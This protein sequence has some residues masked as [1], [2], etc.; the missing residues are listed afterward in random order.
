[1]RTALL[2]VTLLAACH[3]AGPETPPDAPGYVSICDQQPPATLPHCE[4]TCG[5]GRVDACS[6]HVIIADQCSYYQDTTEDCDGAAAGLGCVDLGYYGGTPSCNTACRAVATGCGACAT[7]PAIVDCHADDALAAMTAA[8]GSDPASSPATLAVATGGDGS[9]LT[10]YQ[11]GSGGLQPVAHRAITGHVYALAGAPGGGW[12]A[13]IQDAGVALVR[14]SADLSTATEQ[15]IW[16]GVLEQVDLAAGPDGRALIAWTSVTQPDNGSR[17]VWTAVVDATAIIAPAAITDPNPARLVALAVTSDGASFFV[18]T[19]G[20]LTRLGAAGGVLST[21]ELPHPGLRS[22]SLFALSWSG[23]TG[24]EVR[25]TLASIDSDVPLFSAQR[26]DAAGA[27]IGAPIALPPELVTS[28]Y[29]SPSWIAVGDQLIGLRATAVEGRPSK[30]Q[31][32]RLDAAGAASLTELGVTELG[33]T[34]SGSYSL[35]LARFGTRLA[36]SWSGAMRPQ[37]AVIAP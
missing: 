9:T 10:L 13:V 3:S 2:L 36:A 11:L 17:P 5:N 19:D 27:L 16:T 4:T 22:I 23:T 18:A 32:V 7:G 15:S 34:D 1:M 26:F 33:A 25:S 14:L 21:T 28:V 35:V 8:A 12:W 30:L 29:P 31:L 37:L 20:A 24:W 6:R